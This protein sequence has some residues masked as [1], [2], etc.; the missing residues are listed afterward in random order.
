MAKLIERLNAEA[1][2]KATAPGYYA[3]GAGLYLQVTSGGGKSWIFRYQLRG[4]P[5]EMGLGPLAAYSLAEARH[6][7]AEQR[8]LKSRGVD[9][10][11]HRR[12]HEAAQLAVSAKLVTFKEEAETYI[13]AHSASWR[14]DKHGDQWRNTM[15]AYVY[16]IIG[17]M[18][19][20]DVDTAAVLLVLEPIWTGK[21]ETAHRVRGRI[22]R[23]LSR[24]TSAGRRTGANPA[25]WRG[26]LEHI[27][28]ARRRIAPRRHH[29]AL[30]YREIGAFMVDLRQQPGIAARALELLIL[31]ATR[32][33]ETIG[34][35]TGELDLAAAVWVVPGERTKSGRP[36]RVPLSRRAVE[37]VR[38]LDLQPDATWLFSSR[39]GLPLSNGAFLALLKRMKRTEIT[40]HGFRACFRTWASETTGFPEDVIEMALAHSIGDETVN[41]YKRTDLFGKRARLMQSWAEYCSKP[42]TKGDVV[43]LHTR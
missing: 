3:D 32:T 36:H 5:R 22:E 21:T 9:P 17:D 16:P 29:P 26:H 39:G 33:S 24:A 1:I 42:S 38:G 7:A 30:D 2:R 31:T 6:E 34:A 23:V 43:K 8:K 40:A 12:A 10:L 11:D 41:A 25:Q 19:L 14:N 28:P 4:R 15:K 20:A 35:R 18:S 13:A 27:L 37:L